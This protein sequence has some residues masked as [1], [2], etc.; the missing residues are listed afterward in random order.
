MSVLKRYFFILSGYNDYNY[1]LLIKKLIVLSN[2]PLSF[3]TTIYKQQYFS[4]WSTSIRIWPSTIGLTSITLT[5][6]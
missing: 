4:I 3:M 2:Y 6:G 1:V 5:C